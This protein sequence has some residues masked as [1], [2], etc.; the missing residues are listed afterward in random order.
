MLNVE[1]RSVQSA[2][3]SE[4]PAPRSAVRQRVCSIVWTVEGLGLLLVTVL[5]FIP[6]L[7]HVQEYIF[8]TL[9]VVAVGTAWFEGKQI[10]VRTPID[11]LLFLFIGWVLLTIPFATDPAYSFSEWRKLVAHML[12]FYWVLLVLRVRNDGAAMLRMMAT[13]ALGSLVLNAYGLI[14][15]IWQGGTWKGRGIRA[16]APS[17]NS[18]VLSTYLVIALPLLAAAAISMPI[19]WLRAGCGGVFALAALTQ[20]LTYTRGGWIGSIAEGI[21]FGLITGR[22][23]LVIGVLGGG[24]AFGAGFLFLSQFG[25]QQGVTSTHSLFERVDVWRLGIQEI[26]AHPI[27]G[28]GYGDYTFNMRFGGY[29]EA[30]LAKGLHNTFLMVAMGSGIPALTF[31]VAALVGAVWQLLRCSRHAPDRTV[32]VFVIAVAIMIVG[33]AVRNFF[34]YMFAGNLAYLFWI[35]V[36][37]GLAQA[38]PQ[39]RSSMVRNTGLSSH[40]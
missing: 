27:F 28:V 6:R 5:S 9:L 31:L 33:F 38:A 29:A 17:S 26:I 15:F 19:K 1:N 25:Y 4:D 12:V 7:H 10:W 37:T 36:A 35:L 18:I 20:V 11:P 2:E 32:Y 34:E 23:R 3:I 24:V 39:A 40:E 22:H 14:D 13:V 16:E 8:F 21:A 30:E